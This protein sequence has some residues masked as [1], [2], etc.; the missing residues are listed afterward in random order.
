M[1]KQSETNLQTIIQS[2]WAYKDCIEEVWG[3]KRV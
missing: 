2:F 3:L 1:S